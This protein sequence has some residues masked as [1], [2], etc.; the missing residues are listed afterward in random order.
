MGLFPV[1]KNINGYSNLLTVN[2]I[3]LTINDISLTC[4]KTIK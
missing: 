4:G 1:N 3:L 2:D